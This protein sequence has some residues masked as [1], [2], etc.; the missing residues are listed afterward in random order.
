MVHTGNLIDY[1]L[2]IWQVTGEYVVMWC[3]FPASCI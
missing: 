1:S 3:L 2:W